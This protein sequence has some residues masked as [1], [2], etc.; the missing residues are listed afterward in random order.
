MKYMA[1]QAKTAFSHCN[2]T[3]GGDLWCRTARRKVGCIVRCTLLLEIKRTMSVDLWRFTPASTPVFSGTR[4]HS[5]ASL[6]TSAPSAVP[7]G[8]FIFLR[9]RRCARWPY[10]TSGSSSVASLCSFSGPSPPSS[11]TGCLL[12]FR[13]MDLATSSILQH[14]GRGKGPKGIKAHPRQRISLR[15]FK[16]WEKSL[17]ALHHNTR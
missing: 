14:E 16:S 15:V 3:Q 1:T 7:S 17:P 13:P 6:G 5:T 11:D 10:L 2:R 12:S 8:H 9:F 4:H